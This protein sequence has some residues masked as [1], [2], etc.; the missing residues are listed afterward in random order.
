MDPIAQ[1]SDAL[2]DRVA[3][4]GQG[5][6][7]LRLGSRPRAG[8]LWRSDIVVTSDRAVGERDSVIVAHGGQ[9]V[10]ANCVGRDPATDIAVFR[11]ETPLPGVLPALAATP[12]VG[13]LA[14]MLGAEESGAPTGRLAMVHEVGPAWHSRAGGRI[15]A[16]IRLD[17]RSGADEGGPVLD[18]AGL[19]LGMSA[20]GPRRRV[21][22]IPA[23][24]IA[25]TIDPLLALGHLPRGWLGVGLHPVPV[26]EGFVA[27]AGQARGAMVLNLVADGPA[28][29]AGAMA[30]D[31]LLGVEGFAFGQN[32]R[33]SEV[34]RAERIGEAVDVRLLRA[35]VPMTVSVVIGA[36]PSN[37]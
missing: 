32:R 1:L 7:C 2:A 12:R 6:V 27:L 34:L 31:I 9:E 3:V 25:R 28:A 17:A 20:S 30:G 26:P 19:L 36:R 22:V 4:A 37:S 18:G 23:A 33:L 15:E 10:A 16:L 11:L 29:R 14:V 24:T 13:S 8:I 5:A 35:G 21:L